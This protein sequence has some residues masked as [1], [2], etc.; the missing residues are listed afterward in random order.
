MW[1]SLSFPAVIVTAGRPNTTF[2]WFSVVVFSAAGSF[3]VGR[4]VAKDYIR[5]SVWRI[6]LQDHFWHSEHL[7]SW[8]A[9]H[10]LL[11]CSQV[12][13]RNLLKFLQTSGDFFFGA[14]D[15]CGHSWAL[16]WLF[17]QIQHE[18]CLF[19]LP[20]WREDENKAVG[21]GTP[22]KTVDGD[23]ESLVKGEE[24]PLLAAAMNECSMRR[25]ASIA[26]SSCVTWWACKTRCWVRCSCKLE[27]NW[28]VTYVGQDF[29]RL[30][31]S[32]SSWWIVL[33]YLNANSSTVSEGSCFIALNSA[34]NRRHFESGGSWNSSCKL[35]IKEFN[36]SSVVLSENPSEPRQKDNTECGHSPTT[37]C[38]RSDK[39]ILAGRWDVCSWKRS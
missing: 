35:E 26:L 39:R 34:A 29:V 17:P 37:C 10:L 22:L 28:E 27:I 38:S 15:R 18:L 4:P 13:E 8:P 31:P 33:L 19:L 12:A 9:E 16:C 14:A 3:E 7:W 21:W 36:C 2:S 5:C 23:E 30:S 20:N 24:D 32:L 1:R 25:A 11:D 6:A